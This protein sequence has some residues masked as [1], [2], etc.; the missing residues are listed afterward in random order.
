MACDGVK[1]GERLATVLVI[2]L[3]A[4]DAQEHLLRQVLGV[5][6]GAYVTQAVVEHVVVMPRREPFRR[7]RVDAGG[8]SPVI[9]A[10]VSN[11]GHGF[12][13]VRQRARGAALFGR[14]AV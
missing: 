5:L 2:R 8:V 4:D 6:L 7:R 1:V 3:G 13:A 10:P 12:G 9:P 14:G 11:A